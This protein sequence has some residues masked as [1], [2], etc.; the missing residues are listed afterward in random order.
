MRPF[1][2]PY[3]YQADQDMR[4]LT[5]LV[6]HTPSLTQIHHADDADINILV[7]RFGID[8]MPLPPEANDP[9][10]YGDVSDI[11]DLRTA[12]GT[13]REAQERFQALPA[14]L[15]GRFANDPALM[16]EFVND[17]QNA[18]EAVTLGL[19]ARNPALTPTPPITSPSTQPPEPPPAA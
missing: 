11:P 8:K 14:R 18:E 6:C 16:W 13:V 17:P 15:R 2:L 1:R 3:D 5:Q 9:R 4:V 10:W 7:K 12:L 19:L